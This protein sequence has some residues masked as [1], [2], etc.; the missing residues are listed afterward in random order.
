MKI[1][2]RQLSVILVLIFAVLLPGLNSC[3]DISCTDETTA[4]VKLGFYSDSSRK[5][6]AP[7][8]LTLYGEGIAVKVYDKATITQP[9]LIPLNDSAD[10]AKFIIEINGIADTIEF[11]Y[12]SYPHLI[13]KECGYS[14]FHTLDTVIFTKNKIVSLARVNPDVTTQNVEN[15]QIY[16]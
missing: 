3:V 4:F 16:Y 11:I 15:L 14:I 12:W 2:S 10:Y 5:L 13:S 7:D 6:A 1:M 8:S 9:A